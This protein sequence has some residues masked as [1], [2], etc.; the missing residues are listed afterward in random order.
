MR[1][2]VVM[3]A[4]FLSST[5]FAADIPAGPDAPTGAALREAQRKQFDRTAIEAYST[6]GRRDPAWDA[7]A[8]AYL[9]K[10]K[11]F[12]Y[13]SGGSVSAEALKPL[14][15]ALK[16]K[17]C[18]DPFIKYMIGANLF[19][20]GEVNESLSRLS[21]AVPALLR[22][23]YPIERKAAAAYRMATVL[24]RARKKTAG[25]YYQ[26]AGDFY[27]E[28]LK[29]KPESDIERRLIFQDVVGLYL[30][31]VP[32]EH[33]KEFVAKAMAIEGL[34]VWLSDMIAG[35]DHIHLAWE[36]RGSGWARDVP[37]DAWPKFREHLEK[38]KMHLTRAWTLRPEHPEAAARLVTVAL[39]GVADEDRDCRYWFDQAVRAQVDYA[40]AYT[41]MLESLTPRWGGSL[42]Q[43]I[44]FGVECKQTG[45]FDTDIP[46]KYLTAVQ[47]AV[48]ETAGDLSLW[49]QPAIYAD[50]LDVLAG[51]EALPDSINRRRY[52]TTHVM[53][54]WNAERWDEAARAV[55]AIDGQLAQS[56]VDRYSTR[57]ER[58]L[59]DVAAHTSPLADR[60]N[61]ANAQRGNGNL[62]E[63]IRE[64]EGLLESANNADPL[65]R[66]FLTR[67]LIECRW[68]SR[69]AQGGWVSITP[70]A[71]LL[72][73]LPMRGE[74]KRK[75]IDVVAR[76]ADD[77]CVLLCDT[78]FGRRFELQTN[79]EVSGAMQPNNVNAGL[80]FFYRALPNEQYHIFTAYLAYGAVAVCIKF[81]DD[82][83]RSQKI[84]KGEKAVMRV[85]VWDDQ[86]ACFIDDQMIY[87]GPRL[88]NY[89]LSS[90]N[91]IGLGS[92]E[93]QPGVTVSFNAVKIRSLAEMPEAIAAA[94]SKP[95]ASE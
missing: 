51:Y 89:A 17:K 4:V 87:A 29:T 83:T 11:E 16:A 35:A 66:D 70:E 31:V 50:A 14:G 92:R 3:I 59:Q 10:Y 41:A 38:A 75:G 54:A 22:S 64:F 84:L 33:R 63:A 74:W 60:I 91:R 86:I 27:L 81:E 42:E 88:H 46:S 2:C 1:A 12:Q 30:D 13:N 28:R 44:A 71:G 85:Q 68:L 56:L 24:E 52:F 77:G 23:D 57:A 65:V 26:K 21:V 79:I 45:R 48:N 5:S 36:A 72:G 20:L 90:T 80:V 40:P 55:K 37:E 32:D 73:W 69:F 58:V 6:V 93:W 34:D 78:D 25:E 8:I 76:A 49:R 62:V 39:G 18:A 19:T 67:N 7:E 94:Q 53:L 43:L 15:E 95:E 47:M 9:T 82:Y 61:A